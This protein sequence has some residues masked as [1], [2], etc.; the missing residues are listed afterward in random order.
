MNALI[1]SSASLVALTATPA[2]AQTQAPVDTT[3][4]KQAEGEAV[5]PTSETTNAQGQATSQGEIVVT[6]SR[7]RR[8]NFNT[9]QNVDIVT[10]DDQVLAGTRSTAETLQSASIT[11]GTAQISG[12]FLGFVS[13]GGQAANTVG[14][15]GLGSSRTLVLL[16]GR[17]LAPA[18]VGNQLVAA[19]LNVLPTAMVQRIEVL[20]EGASSIYGSDAIAGVIN[21]ITD[22]SLD[23][24]TVDAFAD[25]P[26]EGSGRTL[27]GSITAGKTFDRGHLTASF[28]YRN[29]Q[30]L[31]QNDRDD[32]R[33]PRDLF[34]QN[35]QEVGQLDPSTGQLRCF[36]FQYDALG[37][38]SG[39]GIYYSFNTGALGRITYPGYTTGNPVIGDA[40]I[41]NDPNL[42][43]S[44]SAAQLMGHILSPVQTYTVFERCL[45][46]RRPRRC[47][48][49]RRSA[50]HP[51]SVT[52]GLCDPAELQRRS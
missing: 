45:R 27:R 21:V 9:P 32:Y 43:P 13:E 7:I 46:P 37:I 8:D 50:L 15:R 14:L 49:V 40:V 6:G 10:R 25:A 38:A 19:D 1:L 35:G 23:G 48:A 44:P 16:N 20:R 34:M 39:Y 12:S 33:C 17:R 52:P 31:R 42:R 47:R 5:P 2:F 30:G 41:V 36:P 51:P 29:F 4:E 11:S 3:P 24:I 22:T 18:G 26:L 28:E